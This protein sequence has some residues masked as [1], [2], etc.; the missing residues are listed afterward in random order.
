LSLVA[1]VAR[2]L[3]IS[4]RIGE[5]AAAVGY[6]V[7]RVDEPAQL[8]TAGD[9]AVAFVD[10]AAREHGWGEALV[11]WAAGSGITMR[12]RLVVFGPHTD[13]EAHAEARS[14]G[15]GPMVARS[16][17][18]SSLSGYLAVFSATASETERLERSE[19]PPQDGPLPAG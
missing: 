18:I 15:I 3:I 9:V 17:L 13:L 14:A 12:P 1:I 8:P 19:S 4:S 5:A 11:A 2:D 16:K 6:D 10:W 7:V